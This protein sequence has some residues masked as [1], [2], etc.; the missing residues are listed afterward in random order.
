MKI[1]TLVVANEKGQ[2]V[3]PK[4]MREAVGIGEDTWLQ[5]VTS[6]ESIVMYPITDVVRR[7]G[8]R[9]AFRD[10]LVR[11]AGAWGPMSQA[12]KAREKQRRKIELEAAK[13][14]RQAW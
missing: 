12:E 9:T 13:R 5:M 4:A 3:I 8:S 1:G 14:R 11:T 7:W 2:I 6:G 10:V